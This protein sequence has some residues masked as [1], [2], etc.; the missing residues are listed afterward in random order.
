MACVLTQLAV[1]V[2]L[3][4]PPSFAVHSSGGQQR[5][6]STASSHS[7][8]DDDST[9]ARQQQTSVTD[10][11][12]SPP[13]SPPPSDAAAASKQSASSSSSSSSAA[14]NSCHQ[15]KTAKDACLLLFCSSA[16]EKGVRKRRCRKKYCEA[17][18]RRSYNPE[19][20]I[21]SKQWVCPS[22]LGF[23]VCAACSRGGEG[24][25]SKEGL[26]GGLA[27]LASMSPIIL[28]LLGIDERRLAQLQAVVN[29]PQ[30]TASL[31]C[32]DGDHLQSGALMAMLGAAGGAAAAG[33]PVSGDA[34]LGMQLQDLSLQQHFDS[35]QHQQQ[36]IF[37]P[38]DP[39]FAAVAVAAALPSVPSMPA[40]AH[41]GMQFPAAPL[42]GVVQQ[43]QRMSSSTTSSSTVSSPYASSYSAA[44]TSSSVSTSPQRNAGFPAYPALPP[45]A[46]PLVLPTAANAVSESPHRSLPFVSRAHTHGPAA[47]N[48]EQ[49]SLPFDSMSSQQQQR[50]FSQPPPH[51]S[52]SS[53]LSQSTPTPSR[54]LADLD[55]A[56][57][58]QQQQV[59]RKRSYSNS[60][61]DAAA[62]GDGASGASRQ[63]FF[64]PPHLTAGS[65]DSS[66]HA[67]V[68]WAAVK[69]EAAD[70]TSRHEQQ[71]QQFAEA[72]L[73]R[74]L[75]E[76]AQY[77]P[78]QQQQQQQLSS[79]S[80]S[81][82][83]DSDAYR[84]PHPHSQYETAGAPA[85]VQSLD[86]SFS[87]VDA[88]A[89]LPAHTSY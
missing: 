23:C 69:S 77:K 45:P 44:S 71:L 41:E 24:D 22:C 79:S 70:W 76:A 60:L 25:V 31:L 5:R 11:D 50:L 28:H 75:Q 61:G 67:A 13:A 14:G 6:A 46:S 58:Q 62:V 65:G 9:Q 21:A 12:E 83:H 86:P 15:C 4:A 7:S 42:D 82:Q 43:Q 19:V 54:H 10:S 68:D 16:A 33:R 64:M 17:C 66:R 39:A 18:L 81:L 3:S 26:S 51:P 74:R 56:Y 73:M 55:A 85:P 48:A 52:S 30:L 1:D 36:P 40:Y 29:S 53:L 78:D 87:Y 27:T 34:G 63:R 2:K 72:E 57:L 20:A 80:V 59:S 32:G 84:H 89:P 49:A 88:S 47:D 38:N 35:P 37:H 8:H